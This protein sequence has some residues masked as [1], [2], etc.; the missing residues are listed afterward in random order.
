MPLSKNTKSKVPVA[1]VLALIACL[2]LLCG[3]VDARAGPPRRMTAKQRHAQA[4]AAAEQR[5]RDERYY[6]ERYKEY[7]KA[8]PSPD[9]AKQMIRYQDRAAGTQTDAEATHIQSLGVGKLRSYLKDREATCSGCIE[10]VHLVERAMQVRGWETENQRVSNELTPA[11]FSAENALS[12]QHGGD[13]GPRD[14]MGNPM[15]PTTTSKSQLQ[16]IQLSHGIQCEE[17]LFNGTQYCTKVSADDAHT[18]SF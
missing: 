4:K 10:K 6:E 11:Q 15:V 1:L 3:T 14:A 2:A 17:A 5:Q 16:A 13:V 12:V 18:S 7:Q 9:D 8:L